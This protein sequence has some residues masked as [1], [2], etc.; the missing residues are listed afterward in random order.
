[1]AIGTHC[2]ECVFYQEDKSCYLG[3]IETFRKSGARI[4]ENPDIQIDRICQYRRKYGWEN[5][6]VVTL[7]LPS[8]KE[9]VESEVYIFGTI[10][11]LVKDIESLKQKIYQLSKVKYIERFLVLISHDTTVPQD[12]VKE[13]AKAIDYTDYRCILHLEGESTKNVLD[14]FKKSKGGFFFIVESDKQMS[15]SLIEDVN[16][17]INVRLSRTAHI[18]PTS[19]LHQSVTIATIYDYVF[20]DVG[21]TVANKLRETD[22][23][24]MVKTWEEVYETISN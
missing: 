22:G 14:D 20:G 13:E 18:A 7:D 10:L 8:L 24:Y 11:I 6:N 21:E 23:G 15:D 3:N 1:M 19:G 16:S 4:E 9:R 2:N 5:V 17:L 12:Q